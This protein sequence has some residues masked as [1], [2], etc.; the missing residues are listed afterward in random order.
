MKSWLKKI[1]S[2][3]FSFLLVAFVSLVFVIAP[4]IQKSEQYTVITSDGK[5]YYAYLPAVFLHNSIGDQTPDGRFI[6]DI[7]GKGVNKYYAGTAV[8]ILPFFG[9][10][11]LLD[12]EQN[13]YSLTYQISVSIAGVF[14]LILGLLYLARL[15]VL[16][17]FSEVAISLTILTLFFGTNLFVY[18][19]FE[20]SMSHIYSFFWTTGF[21]F[22]TKKHL[23][24]GRSEL[25]YLSAIFLGFVVL[26]RPINGL[27]ILVIPFLA[28][29]PLALKKYVYSS[30]FSRKGWMSFLIFSGIVAV[31]PIV[32]Y[33]QSGNWWVWSY[34]EE[35]FNFTSPS[36][37]Q[38]LFSFRK[39]AF[40]YTPLLIVTV[41]SAFLWWRRNKFQSATIL[42]FFATLVYV[43]SSWWNWYYGPSFGQRPLVDFYGV[44]GILLAYFIHHV[45]GV[46][47]RLFSL[48]FV[49]SCVVLNL[50]Q[51]YQYRS[52]ILSS[53]DMNLEKYRATFLK[54]DDKWKQSLGGNFDIF[55]YNSKID[56]VDRATLLPSVGKE[57]SAAF[58]YT[59]KEFGV[60]VTFHVDSSYLSKRGLYLLVD[61]QL[62]SRK[63]SAQN[64]AL[65]VVDIM[66]S[67]GNNYH[68]YTFPIRA[69]PPTNLVGWKRETYQIELP[70]VHRV[71]DKIKL[72]I[73]NKERESFWV[74]DVK[75]K[76]L[77]IN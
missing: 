14:Y 48:S 15:L 22:F 23:L 54:V 63:Q 12:K 73:W 41:L 43:L 36:W 10:A 20:P 26:V 18:G 55:L 8:S 25:F 70:K 39:G 16:F 33:L 49:L 67:A 27:I 40:V 65:F 2:V 58:D 44:S 72:Y 60:E 68:Y 53:W 34:S 4:M 52:G 66:D 76:M 35:G 56:T 62:N 32:W 17:R 29:S 71:G 31:Q 28:G 46:K 45:S 11:T 19:V 74:K 21:L 64:K 24:T 3:Q 1:G 30:V 6:L 9:L 59:E 61:L 5:G 77:T 38:F 51:T 42:F 57:G 13:G 47:Q 7:N 37:F 50:I 69:I 75:F